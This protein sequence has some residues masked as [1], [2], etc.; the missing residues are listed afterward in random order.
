M[1]QSCFCAAFLGFGTTFAFRQN[2]LL[3][4]YFHLLFPKLWFLDSHRLTISPTQ[5]FHEICAAVPE[6]TVVKLRNLM[7]LRSGVCA[8]IMMLCQLKFQIANLLS[9]VVPRFTRSYMNMR[10]TFVA[11]FQTMWL[12]FSEVLMLWSLSFAIT[13]LYL[14]F[15]CRIPTF[16]WCWRRDV[17]RVNRSK[18]LG[19]R[20]CASVSRYSAQVIFVPKSERILALMLLNN[21]NISDT[22]RVFLLSAS[23]AAAFIG[24]IV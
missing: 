13:V 18:N 21:S 10:L 22:Q 24:V 1:L 2:S 16:H 6:P 11:L 8:I 17:G 12:P 5:S 3:A 4:P 23:A 14:L 19:S 15:L 7:L 20:F 9:L